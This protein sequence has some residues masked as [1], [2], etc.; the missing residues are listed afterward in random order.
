MEGAK[1][2]KIEPGCQIID[3][4]FIIKSDSEISASELPFLV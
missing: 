3:K 2:I 1:R 4:S